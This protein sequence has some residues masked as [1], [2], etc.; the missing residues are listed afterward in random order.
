[1]G[2]SIEF[3]NFLQLASVILLALAICGCSRPSAKGRST[4]S[5]AYP[6]PPVSM[7][8]EHYTNY[9]KVTPREVLVNPELAMLC[10]GVS[11]EAVEA[12]RKK[13]GP[14]A[15]AA[16]LIY[17]SR[18]AALAFRDGVVPY[19]VGA[20][21]V[22]EKMI[23]SYID[24]N[25]SFHSEKNGGGGMVKRAPGFDPAHGDWEYFYFED[26]AKIKNGKISSCVKCHES[27]KTTD[28]VFGTWRSSHESE[29]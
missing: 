28:Y 14:H 16:I 24:N 23:G 29:K 8:A 26:P 19:P 11:Q 10:N 20:V 12:A 21:I 17:M 15:N 6:G 22:K 18:P 27:A 1:M 2:S 13:Y 5:V 25:G 9:V 3:M 4:F 7:I